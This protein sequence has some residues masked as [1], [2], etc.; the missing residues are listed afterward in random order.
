MNIK[1]IISNKRGIEIGGPS[2]LLFNDKI[3]D[4]VTYL[5]NV[6]FSKTTIWRTFA[7]DLYKCNSWNEGKS[8]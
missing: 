7:D 8:T 2:N 6:V 1:D 5:D 4:N 3:Y